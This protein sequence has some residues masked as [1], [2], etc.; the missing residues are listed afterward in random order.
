MAQIL[1]ALF[2]WAVLLGCLALA[3]RFHGY[4]N[5]LAYYWYKVRMADAGILVDKDG[6]LVVLDDGPIPPRVGYAED[7][8]DEEGTELDEHIAEMEYLSRPKLKKA[9]H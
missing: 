5:A 1:Q 2:P 4:L 3:Y 8:D 6:G 7:D 9:V